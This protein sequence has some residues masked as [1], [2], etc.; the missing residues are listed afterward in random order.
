MPGYFRSSLLPLRPIAAT[1]VEK[2][3]TNAGAVYKLD[4]L[5]RYIY[6]RKI[7]AGRV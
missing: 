3:A 1:S 2:L 5:V 7:S 4:R 6:G